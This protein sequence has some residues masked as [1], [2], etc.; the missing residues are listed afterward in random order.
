[1]PTR[2]EDLRWSMV[3]PMGFLERSGLGRNK[4]GRVFGSMK[5]R[6]TCCSVCCV[7]VFV[8][9]CLLC[10]LCLYEHLFDFF[11]FFY[12]ILFA[13]LLAWAEGS[14]GNRV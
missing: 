1:M 8:C 4:G 12:C 9:I 11:M 2:S 10:F 3:D 13:C 7:F 5:G 6:N 14:G